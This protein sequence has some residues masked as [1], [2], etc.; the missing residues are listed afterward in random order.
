MET[1][2]Y[3][4]KELNISFTYFDNDFLPNFYSLLMRSQQ[5]FY[6][7]VF[8]IRSV[9]LRIIIPGCIFLM[10]NKNPLFNEEPETYND[11]NQF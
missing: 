2:P 1:D 11:L 8:C 5:C 10:Q 6:V 4:E 9:Y 7:I 3:N